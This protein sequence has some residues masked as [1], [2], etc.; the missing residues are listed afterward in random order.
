M[1]GLKAGLEHDADHKHVSAMTL[2]GVTNMD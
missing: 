1:V 2:A